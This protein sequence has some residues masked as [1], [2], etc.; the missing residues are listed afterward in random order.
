MCKCLTKYVCWA[1]SK[2]TFLAPIANSTFLPLYV[3]YTCIVSTFTYIMKQL[4]NCTWLNTTDW[5]ATADYRS[6]PQTNHPLLAPGLAGVCPVWGVTIWLTASP[7]RPGG[8]ARPI[9]SVTLA[10]LVHWLL[11]TPHMCTN[12]GKC[13]TMQRLSYLGCILWKYDYLKMHFSSS[14]SMGGHL[15]WSKIT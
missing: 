2:R 7:R 1:K 14:F 13:H 8:Q 4:Q 10:P 12:T 6:A 15:L 11:Q 3:V 9:K 5:R